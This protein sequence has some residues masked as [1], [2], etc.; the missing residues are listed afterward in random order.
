MRQWDGVL[1]DRTEQ[2]MQCI[3]RRQDPTGVVDLKLCIEH[4]AFDFMVRCIPFVPASHLRV[5]T[6]DSVILCLE[7]AAPPWY[8]I[9]QAGITCAD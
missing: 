6:I 9:L 8:D 3:P 7:Q 2:L 5:H 1:K 4:W